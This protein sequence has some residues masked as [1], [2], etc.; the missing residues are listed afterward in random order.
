MVGYLLLALIALS[1]VS[2]F[3][4]RR[5]AIATVGGRQH[6]LHS[7]PSYHGA[8]VAAWVGIPAILLVLI[9]LFLQGAVID[10]LLL[11][12]LPPGTTDGWDSGQINLLLSQIKSV[13]AGHIFGEPSQTVMMAAERY[14]E[15]QWIARLAMVAAAFSVAV[16][17]FWIAGARIAPA[18]RARHGTERVMS[19]LMIVCSL[20]AIFTTLG[21]VL[22]LLFEALRFFDRVSPLEFFFGLRWEP[23]FQSARVR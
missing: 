1:L 18:F 9:W 12:S 4:G 15:W 20:I 11:W 19:G 16:V 23:Q 7:R 5:R 10:R 22:S 13:A 6:D 21:I 14:K 8:F 3:F 17:G 2:Y